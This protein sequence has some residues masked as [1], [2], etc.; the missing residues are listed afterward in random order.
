MIGVAAIGAVPATVAAFGSWRNADQI[1]QLSD[2]VD[3]QID[4]VRVQVATWLDTHAA[5]GHGG[6]L[7]TVA[8]AMACRGRHVAAPETS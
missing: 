6:Q 5:D 2:T 3:Q 7:R 8:A 4:S 1:R